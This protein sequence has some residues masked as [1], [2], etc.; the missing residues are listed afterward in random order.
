MAMSCV[1]GV[2]PTPKFQ[3]SLIVAGVVDGQLLDVGD[4]AGGGGEE[5]A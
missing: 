1:S 2:P 4:A 5:C 3:L